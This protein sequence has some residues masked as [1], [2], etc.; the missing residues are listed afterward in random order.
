MAEQDNQLLLFFEYLETITEEEEKKAKLIRVLSIF[1]DDNSKISIDLGREVPTNL[2]NKDFI[3]QFSL[4]LK[5]SLAV[6]F[7]D[8]D[9]VVKLLKKFQLQDLKQSLLKVL[10]H[11][12]TQYKKY[13]GVNSLVEHKWQLSVVEKESSGLNKTKLDNVEVGFKFSIN[14]PQGNRNEKLLKMDYYE[15]SEIFENLKKVENQLKAFK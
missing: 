3:T 9:S 14:T 13:S 2:I 11:A 1:F 10:G 8:D 4:L 5:Y 15:F 12:V 7:N 6:N